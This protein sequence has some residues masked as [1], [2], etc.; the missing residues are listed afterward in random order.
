MLERK[1][2]LTSLY[3]QVH[4]ETV[5]DPGINRLR[6]IHVEIDEG[7]AEAYGWGDIPLGHDFYTTAQGV[8]FTISEAA[9]REVLKRLVELNLRRKADEVARG[10]TLG[11]GRRAKH[12]VDQLELVEQ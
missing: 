1:L 6:D 11:K 7:V 8:R 3:N 10:L 9:R 12:H 5:K 2:G 4:N